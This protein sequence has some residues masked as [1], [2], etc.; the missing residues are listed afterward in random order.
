MRGSHDGSWENAHLLRDGYWSAAPAAVDTT[1]TYDLVVVG[2]GISGL[3]AA[4]FFPSA[5][6]QPAGFSSSTTTTTSAAM[7]N[8]TS[9]VSTADCC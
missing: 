9:F 6:G 2:G 3:A 8:A 1:E 4:Y 7:R 5:T